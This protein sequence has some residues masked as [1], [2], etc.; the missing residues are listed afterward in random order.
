MANVKAFGDVAKKELSMVIRQFLSLKLKRKHFQFTLTQSLQGRLGNAEPTYVDKNQKKLYIILQNTELLSNT[1]NYQIKTF[2][3]HESLGRNCP[4][5]F[6]P[7]TFKL[8]HLPRK[9]T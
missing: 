5:V 4:V 2:L 3:L 7:I 9:K 6:G 1:I 8:G